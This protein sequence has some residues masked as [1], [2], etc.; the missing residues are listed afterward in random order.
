MIHFINYHEI[1]KNIGLA[2][3]CIQCGDDGSMPCGEG[4]EGSSIDCPGQTICAKL[5]CSEDGN[6]TIFRGCGD[7]LKAAMNTRDDTKIE[8]CGDVV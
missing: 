3:T 2:V 7:W 8:D 1:L 4:D 5:E 6:T